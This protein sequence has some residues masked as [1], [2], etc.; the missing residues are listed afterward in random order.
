MLKHPHTGFWFELLPSKRFLHFWACNDT[1]QVLSSAIADSLQVRKT[2]TFH[3]A[4]NSHDYHSKPHSQPI[5]RKESDIR[6]CLENQHLQPSFVLPGAFSCLDSNVKTPGI[7]RKWS[8]SISSTVTSGKGGLT[9]PRGASAGSL[10]YLGL[11]RFPYTVPSALGFSQV[12][13]ASCTELH[14]EEQ[15]AINRH[16]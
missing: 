16:H 14:T 13:A 9:A 8:L 5:W 6:T 15:Y 1:L 3:C 12:L 7:K 4:S 10:S 11:L 2:W